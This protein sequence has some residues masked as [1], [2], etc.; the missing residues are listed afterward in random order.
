MIAHCQLK[1]LLSYD[2]VTGIWTWLHPEQMNRKHID[3][4]AG[5]IS[6]HGYR[7]ITFS[8]TKYR[9]ARL[10]WFYM[11][12]EWPK[13]DIDHINKDKADDRWSNL[14]D[15]LH[16][17]NALNRDLQSN[18][19]SGVRGVHWD[20]SRSKWFVQVKKDGVNHFI[21]RYDDFD[22]AIAARDLAAI[23]LHGDFAVL[24][25]KAS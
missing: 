5:T 3:A 13:D 14:R 16:S 25:Q 7:I 2:P 6:V 4:V 19:A 23:E 11:T 18:N 22:E 20:S 24:Y 12:G 10:A 15:I 8:G 1:E 17:D 21:G 9:S